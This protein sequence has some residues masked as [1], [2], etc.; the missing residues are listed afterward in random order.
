MPNIPVYRNDKMVGRYYEGAYNI[1]RATGESN[2]TLFYITVFLTWFI[3]TATILPD[4]LI[5]NYNYI[6]M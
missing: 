2:L 1:D 4:L 5:S 3:S 6:L